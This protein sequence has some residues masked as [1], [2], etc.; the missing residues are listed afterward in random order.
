MTAA[1]ASPNLIL[2][3]SRGPG[4]LRA[5]AQIWADSA[6][7]CDMVPFERF[8]TGRIPDT[9]EFPFPYMSVIAGGGRP[10]FRS[11]RAQDSLRIVSVHIWVDGDKE[12]D[13]ETIAEKIRRLYCG[14]G[15]CYNYG[16]V[17]DI[18]DGGPPLP[19]QGSDPTYDS[20][21]VVKLLTLC[22]E[23]PRKDQAFLQ[24]AGCR[25]CC[26]RASVGSSYSSHS[27][28]SQSGSQS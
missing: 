23:Q 6:D 25:Q 9:K 27:R 24:G 4:L 3:G 5:F 2:P 11:D 19:H 26:P 1:Q 13:G 12:E 14:S 18:L 20:W 17:Y 22:I 7:A 15:F 28:A 10:A 8:V 21:E 16:Q